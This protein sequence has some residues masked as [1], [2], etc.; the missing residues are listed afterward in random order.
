MD[1]KSKSAGTDGAAGKASPPKRF[2]KDVAV[3]DEDGGGASLRLDGRCVRTPGKALLALPSRALAEAIAEEWRAQGERID[4]STMP[5][6]RLANSAIDGVKGREQAVVGDIVNYAGSDLLCYRAEAPKGL[7]AAQSAHWDDVLAFARDAAQG[8]A[9]PRPRRGACGAAA[10]PRW[11]TSG[12]R[13][14]ASMR[15][16]SPRCM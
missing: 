12:G 7:V 15:S 10:K 6:T 13:S 11:R 8:A 16:R 5:L 9:R 3:K 1:A 2:Y 4:P 14:R